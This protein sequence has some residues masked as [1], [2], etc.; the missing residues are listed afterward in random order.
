[1]AE[2]NWQSGLK[3]ICDQCHRSLNGGFAK[4]HECGA[5]REEF[6]EYGSLICDEI[7]YCIFSGAKTDVFLPC[8]HAVWAP[9][10][11][12]M[13]EAAWL[14]ASFGYT[15]IAYQKNPQLRSLGPS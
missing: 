12:S 11:L 9:Y 7:G 2:M 8:G 6:R 4:C 10:F 3:L 14:D 15:E 13:I 5:V 1:M